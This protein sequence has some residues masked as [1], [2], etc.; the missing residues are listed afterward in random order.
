[1][2][3][4]FV[5]SRLGI[6]PAPLRHVPRP[7]LLAGLDAA[8][9]IPLVLLSAGPGTGKTVLLAEWAR[10]TPLRVA[11]LCPA[12]GDDDPARFRALLSAALDVPANPGSGR[13][14]PPQGRTI[15]FVHA[16]LEQLP[17]AG[18]PLVLAIDDAHVLTGPNV[19]SLLDAL[20]RCGHPRLH[21]VLASRGDPPLPLHRYRLAGHLRELRAAD[22]ALTSGETR[23]LL[24][25]HDV[26]LPVSALNALTVRT[27]GWAAGVRL[28]AMRMEHS[29]APARLVRELSFDHGG[30]GEYLLAEV[31]DPQPPA[32]RRV[33]IETSF[34]NEVTRPLAEA[35]TGIDGAGEMLAAFARDSSF[36]STLDPAA[37][38]FRYHRLF[39][40]VLRYLLARDTGDEIR[41]LAA[42]AAARFE[43]EG[44]LGNALY[45]AARAGDQHQA[46]RVLVYGGLAHAYTRRESIPVA[47]LAETLA[48][49]PPSASPGAPETPKAPQTLQTLQTPADGASSP[50]PDITLAAAVLRA[51]TADA[52]SAATARELE[53][54]RDIVAA[55]QQAD[56]ALLETGALAELM[57]GLRAGDSRAVDNAASRLTGVRPAGKRLTDER[58]AGKRLTGQRPAGDLRGAVLLAQASTHFWDGAYPDVADLL[59][60]ALTA[61]LDAGQTALAVEALGM[62]AYASRY[63]GRPRHADDAALAACGLIREHPGLRAPLSLRLSAVIRLV[64]KADLAGAARQLRH[65]PVPDAVSADPGLAA[66]RGLWEATVTAQSGR[67]DEARAM[68]EYVSAG[69]PLPPLLEIH[70]DVELSEI[71]IRLGRPEAALG[72][73]EP[74]RHG[75]FAALAD[76]A[77]ARACLFLDDIPGAQQC[78]RRVLTAAPRQAGR[79]TLVEAMLASARIAEREHDT[80]RTLELITNALDVAQSDIVLPFVQAR[81]TLGG[82]LSRHPGV[83]RRWP[84]PPGP[85]GGTADR[86]PDGR[87]PGGPRRPVPLTDRERS[88]LTYLASSMTA[89][90]IADEL[91]V[92]VNTVKTHL[93]AIY[94]KL[95]A[96][97]RR[98]AVRRAR[99]LELL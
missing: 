29:P 59:G 20:V 46:A 16:L 93:G 95:S 21:L 60:Q 82:L 55:D 28:T 51:I 15:D 56:E 27:E 11:W 9:D 18:P 31:L 26:T 90:E 71:E 33:L 48:G 49:V 74:H 89:A 73:L 7:R 37:T 42:R 5:D 85:A 96:G 41:M 1:M 57:L 69:T 67:L 22:L 79:Y 72:R 88:V 62:A 78:V 98:E 87:E 61:A 76:V 99:E 4:D 94:R 38:Q 17:G 68:I 50:G 34:L 10:R 45:W 36:A 3:H 8:R 6:P 84:G 35:V 58:S 91:Y 52:G 30:A 65:A 77:C 25:A 53:W 75:R 32:L 40:E 43:S 63:C 19:T 80:D 70:R 13:V 86:E 47:E 83:A 12:P 2:L 14:V 39:A 92:S 24:A 97:G 44:D 81:E 64:Q 66:A 54:A 23:E